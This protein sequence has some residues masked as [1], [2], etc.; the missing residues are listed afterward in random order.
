MDEKYTNLKECERL[1]GK[2]V[3]T[4]KKE[5]SGK[6]VFSNGL[7]TAVS[8]DVQ[9]LTQNIDGPL[10]SDTHKVNRR[11]FAHISINGAEV[12]PYPIEEVFETKEELINAM[13]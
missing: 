10:S 7:C 8:G 6:F 5:K 3:Y 11:L 4:L 12:E 2:S 9:L 1:L 13:R